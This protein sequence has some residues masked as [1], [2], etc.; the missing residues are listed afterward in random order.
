MP[1]GGRFL[2]EPMLIKIEQSTCLPEDA[3][4][5]EPMLIVNY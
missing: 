3:F 5:R 4:L 1:V 2:R